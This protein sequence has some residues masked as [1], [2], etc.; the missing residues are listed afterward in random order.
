[1]ACKSTLI[2]TGQYQLGNS[3]N[4]PQKGPTS[5]NLQ[6]AGHNVLGRSVFMIYGNNI[7]N[8][9]SQSCIIMSPAI[10]QQISTSGDHVLMVQP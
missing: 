9:A 2:H 10:R 6:P 5:M 3:Y 8:N 7:Q 4:H 1:M